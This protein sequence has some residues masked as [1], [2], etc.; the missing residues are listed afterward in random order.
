M[1]E[2]KKLTLG[3]CTVMLIRWEAAPA[4]RTVVSL[5]SIAFMLSVPWHAAEAR[6]A[7]AAQDPVFQLESAGDLPGARALL[8]QQAQTSG[9]SSAEQ[10][11]ADFLC[12]HGDAG[13]RTAYAKWASDETD[14]TRKKL[15]L[16]QIALLDYMG[17]REE[18]LTKDLELYRAAGGTDFSPPAK[19]KAA[20]SY[21]T[22]TVPG[23]LSAFARMAALAPDLAAE[24]LL[25]ALARNV[26]TNG[27]EA[28]GNESLQQTEYLRLLIRYVGQARDLQAMANK[29]RQIVIPNCD[30]EQTGALLKVLGYRMRGS[31][32]A[33]IIL[34]TV[35]P[36]RAFLTVDS[37]FPLTQ[38]EQDLRAN[39]R[40]ELPYAPT[41]VPVLY[42][43]EYWQA[44]LGRPNQSDFLDGFLSDPSLCRLY[45]GLSHLDQATAEALRKQAPAS[46]LK[47]YSHVMDFFGGMF[48]IR[49]GAAV[50]PGS[51]KSWASMVGVAPSNPGAF[52]EKLMATDDGW[53]ASYFDSLSR[54]EGPVQAYLT[55][56]ERMKRFYDALRGKITTPGPARPVFRSS[57]ELMLLTTGLRLEADGQ[58]HI[59]GSIAVWQTLFLKHPH[60]KYDGK[61]TKSAVNWHAKDD[62]VEALFALS[63]KSVD[64]E[65]L[66][67]FL[68]LN[69]IDKVR[70]KPISAQ[71]AARLITSFRP[72]D[73]QYAL[74]ADSPT[75]SEAAIIRYLDLCSETMK[76]RD[77]LLRADTQGML[78]ALV[79]LWRALCRQGSIPLDA[80]DASFSKLIEPFGQLK[81]PAELFDAGRAG[82]NLLLATAEPKTEGTRQER[83][84]ELLVGKL[85]G[86]SPS[87]AAN[88]LR[89]FDAQ[90]LVTLD[91]LFFAVDRIE[92]GATDIKA[93][94]GVNDQ[95]K[96]LAETEP[97][98]GSLSSEEKNSLAMGYWSERHVEQER[99]MNLESLLKGQDN[100]KD[101]R[102]ALAPFL[103]DSLVG[104]VYSF[105]A[106]AGAQLLLTNPML[107]RNHDF[108]G[109]EGSPAAWRQTELAGSGWPQ[110]A[111]G[112]LSGSLISLPYAIAEAEQ[113]FLSPK[114]E[115]ALIWGDLV[116]QMIAG[117]TV[118][119]WRNVTPE[120]VRWVSLRIQ[121]GRILLATAALDS[122]VE[123]KVMNSLRRYL[124][125]SRVEWI[126]G[127]L[128]GNAFAN[129]A[130]QVPPSVLTAISLDRELKDVAPDTS[131]L[132]IAELE[133]R[134]D[135]KLS[136]VGIANAFGTPKPTLTHSYQPGLLYLRTFP[137]LMGYSSRILAESWESNNL[138]YAALADEAGLPVA[139]LDAYVPEWN[140]SAIEN[141]FATHL[142]DWPALLRSLDALGA[143]VRQRGT[144]GMAMLGNSGN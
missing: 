50:V 117:V 19:R 58:P 74:F 71:T 6:A 17:G 77:N 24:D 128:H 132:A 80:R 76:M 26:V 25:P 43:S 57:T 13:C 108:I 110:S 47:I 1:I 141:I 126:E 97:V 136:M 60:G 38:L 103:R 133:A 42:T 73:S 22:I 37:G 143:S 67:M 61:L 90:R 119:R 86:G 142:E 49:N 83:L 113:N 109:Q 66:R 44:A 2:C 53:L 8:L 56:P 9:N 122:S 35:N 65:P 3:K 36:T 81:Q 27:Y 52:F 118:N 31:C 137:A 33:D 115:Q 40:F 85:R 135:P 30:S 46:K 96:R 16:R 104:L 4:M 39:H 20:A 29:E 91:S 28:A 144:Q 54:I 123:P 11:L 12:R 114:R 63:R 84:V 64:N 48:Q 62:L 70:S 127:H 124:P 134:N 105:Y 88:F 106:P 5:A 7:S 15:A 21:S 72:F 55:Q 94:K 10:A 41:Q 95:L 130:R 45:L 23:P 120:Q 32:G 111:G 78:Q 112:R 116:P 14:P 140:R 69:D 100:K 131:S 87:P 93:L 98:H 125:P 101:P 121:R 107:V 92:K 18:D 89:V 68:M 79:E 102:A 129:T 82:V 75:L 99:K 59:P 138:Y 139:Q 34:E 51:A